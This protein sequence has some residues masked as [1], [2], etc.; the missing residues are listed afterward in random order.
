MSVLTYQE[1]D[2]IHA[3]IKANGRCWKVALAKQWAEARYP[4]ISPEHVAA[5]QGLRNASYFG[6]SGLQKTHVVRERRDI[7]G[8]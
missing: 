4:G 7:S 8:C 2:A 1:I 5:L 6:P 3:F